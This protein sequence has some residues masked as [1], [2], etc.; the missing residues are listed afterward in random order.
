ME[1]PCGPQIH[2]QIT[3]YDPRF[4][5]AGPG[6]CRL[7]CAAIRNRFPDTL[8]VGQKTVYTRD[9]RQLVEWG[10]ARQLPP[11]GLAVCSST[12][13][14]SGRAASRISMSRSLRMGQGA[15]WEVFSVLKQPVGAPHHR[16]AA[17]DFTSTGTRASHGQTVYTRVMLEPS[18][19][20]DVDVPSVPDLHETKAPASPISISIRPIGTSTS[21]RNWI[22]HQPGVGRPLSQSLRFTEL[23]SPVC[24]LRPSSILKPD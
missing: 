3:A 17:T 5:R 9:G 16:T 12:S 20:A 11:S 6:G 15:S 1:G 2:R 10:G 21:V 19:R 18:M 8:Y 13:R 4:R 7:Y 14:T 23:G 22:K 24:A